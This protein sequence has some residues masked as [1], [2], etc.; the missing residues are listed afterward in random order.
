MRREVYEETELFVQ[1]RSVQYINTY[2]VRN[3][4]G[5][6][7]YALYAMQLPPHSEINLNPKEHKDFGWFSNTEARQVNT[8]PHTIDCIEK[9]E[10]SEYSM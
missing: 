3:D 7:I 2:Y 10:S 9:F 5:D 1:A 4:F 6:F 8:I